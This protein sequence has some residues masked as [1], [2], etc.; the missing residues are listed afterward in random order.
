MQ[1]VDGRNPYF[2]YSADL[3]KYIREVSA[4]KQ[5]ILLI[6][7]ADYLSEDLIKHWN[8]YF[9]EKGVT[10]IFFSAL[11]EQQKL[12]GLEDVEEEDEEDG[13]E[14][15]EEAE[16]EQR[17]K[18][19]EATGAFTRE[20]VKQIQQEEEA[21]KK[22][23]QLDETIEEELKFNTTEV[24]TRN[25][26]VSLLKQKARAEDCDPDNRLVV[27]TVGYPNV[28]KSSVINVLFGGKKVGVAAMPGKTKHF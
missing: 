20:V 25:Q 22:K 3:E 24:F 21:E 4:D 13:E 8:E 26:L 23:Q 7:K 17:E 14:S 10:H 12:D 28:G 15:D 19:V 5:F 1:I 11:A 6:N 27:G 16:E 2:F 9:N 18:P